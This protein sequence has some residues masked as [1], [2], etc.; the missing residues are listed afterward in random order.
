MNLFQYIHN[1]GQQAPEHLAIK[2]SSEQISYKQ[3]EQ[4]INCAANY[5][6]TLGYQEGDVVLLKLTNKLH[7][8]LMFLGGLRSGCIVVPLPDDRKPQTLESLAKRVR[9]K[10]I[11]K[12]DNFSEDIFHDTSMSSRFDR[13]VRTSEFYHITSGSTGGEKVSIRTVDALTHE[14][15]AYRDALNFTDEDMLLGLSPLY[16]SFALGAVIGGAFTSGACMYIVDKF[17]P[18]TTLEILSCEKI[19]R[20]VLVPAMV[21]LLCISKTDYDNKENALKTVLVGGGPI[22][23]ALKEDFLKKFGIYPSPTY[24]STE[25]GGL[26]LCG[27]KKYEDSVGVP[28][29]GVEVKIVDA[30][31]KTGYRKS[32]GEL[33]VRCP[34]MQREY[35]DAPGNSF[36]EEEYFPMG[37]LVRADEDGYIYIIGRIKNMINI[38]GRKVNPLE[39]EEVIKKMPNVSDCV[40]FGVKQREKEVIKAVIVPKGKLREEDV[41]HRCFEE[42]EHYKLPSMIEMKSDLPKNEMGKIRKDI[43][44]EANDGLLS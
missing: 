21:K 31:G 12:D 32:Q 18:R 43:L 4:S 27:D 28:M 14:G 5:L 10:G 39:I 36:D 23:K 22:S 26:L 40:V 6:Y 34:G 42:L 15:E 17:V 2:T 41:R 44:M 3:L 35:L 25:T 11:I 13:A 30:D 37:D 24:G 38:G 7:F 9:A 33:W 29:P 1:Y 16:H 20:L 8:T 19:T